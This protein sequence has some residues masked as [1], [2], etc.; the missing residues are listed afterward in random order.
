MNTHTYKMSFGSP[1]GRRGVQIVP[2]FLPFA[3]CPFRCVFCAQDKQTGTGCQTVENALHELEARLAQIET[4]HPPLPPVE[5]AFYGG[6][7][8]CLPP[9]VQENCLAATAR[10]RERG[11]VGRVRCSTRP[12]AVSACD[13]HRLRALG[14]DL[15]ELGVQSFDSAAL[16]TSGRGYDGN[17]ARRGCELVK[18]VGLELGIQLLPGMPGVSPDVF[19]ED[20]RLSLAGEPS[21]LRFYPCLVVAGTALAESWRLGHYAPWSRETTVATLAKGLA[22]AWEHHVPVIR[23]SLAP[24]ADLEA[25]ILDGPRHPALGNMIQAEALWLRLSSILLSLPLPLGHS[26]SLCLPAHCQ[27]MYAGYRGALLSRWKALGV[28]K[29]RWHSPDAGDEVAIFIEKDTFFQTD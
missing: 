7:F 27:G 15:V 4:R 24:E 13:L 5:V 3:G 14:L 17:T 9:A 21:C 10:W 18:E 22:L 23:L 6:T 19:L 28:R 8:T 1:S 16:L 25:A 11:I 29:V 2:V 12:D 26:F 20:V